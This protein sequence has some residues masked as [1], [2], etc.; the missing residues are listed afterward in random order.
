M[1]ITRGKRAVRNDKSPSST[2]Q[3]IPSSPTI[4]APAEQRGRSRTTSLALTSSSSSSLHASTDTQPT[5]ERDTDAQITAARTARGARR[6]MAPMTAVTTHVTTELST[7]FHGQGTE[8][9]D[10]VETPRWGRMDSRAFFERRPQEVRMKAPWHNPSRDTD[11]SSSTY[12]RQTPSVSTRDRYDTTSPPSRRITTLVETAAASPLETSELSDDDMDDRLSRLSFTPP[13]PPPLFDMEGLGE[14]EDKNRDDDDLQATSGYTWEKIKESARL[15]AFPLP[16][17]THRQFPNLI[18]ADL[19]SA[20]NSTSSSHN[21]YASPFLVDEGAMIQ[22]NAYE[23][24]DDKD[25]DPFGFTKV[26]RKLEKTR[27]LQHKLLPINATKSRSVFNPTAPTTDNSNNSGSNHVGIVRSMDR[28]LDRTVAERAAT[29]RRGDVKGKGKAI[30]QGPST[31]HP[32][33]SN[34]NGYNINNE[35]DD[36]EDVQRAILLSLGKV[37]DAEHGEGCSTSALLSSSSSRSPIVWLSSESDL[38]SCDESAAGREKGISASTS[39]VTVRSDRAVQGLDDLDSDDD[40]AFGFGDGDRNRVGLGHG[41]GQMPP[42]TPQKKKPAIVSIDSDDDD[43]RSPIVIETTP[44]RMTKPEAG[45]PL[46]MESPV[47]YTAT[48]RRTG[49]KKYLTT[50]QLEAMLP[51]RRRTHSRNE[52]AVVISSNGSSS[53]DE[54]EEVLVRRRRGG[55][56]TG[57]AVT[58]QRSHQKQDTTG[59]KRK[60]DTA[61]STPTSKRGQGSK[62]SLTSTEDKAKVNGSNYKKKDPDENKSSWSAA[63]WAAHQE[64]IKYFQQLDDFELEVEE[65]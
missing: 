23:E 46:S 60:A 57:S 49:K 42:S 52:E 38:P 63:Q 59:K 24:D 26:E 20:N 61:I 3:P 44:K 40:L 43:D 32:L 14:E 29:R 12:K 9:D 19:S 55:L 18:T 1:P 56:S 5:V 36:Q 53:E 15:G 30:D 34:C 64:R 17:H 16:Q 58:K 21:G 41:Q 11:T 6:I 48:G 45:M 65:V 25:D 35:A 7:R 28:N 27:S 10:D 62:A 8:K 33:G 39:L 51:R 50:E 4:P 2:S 13:P 37:F 54:E 31:Q 22:T 47:S